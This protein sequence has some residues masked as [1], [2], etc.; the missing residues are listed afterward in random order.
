[1]AVIGCRLREE[2]STFSIDS[3]FRRMYQHQYLIETNNVNDLQI[4][5]YLGALTSTPDPLP[6]IGAKYHVT[7]DQD[8][9]AFLLG[10]Q[11]K[12][13]E[14]EKGSRRHWLADCNWGPPEP[15]Q[16]TTF[17]ENPL[18]RPAKYSLEWANYTRVLETDISG[19]PVL[20]SADDLFEAI[21][22][23]DA[24]PVLVVTKN[25]W[26]L[27]IIIANAIAYKNAVNSDTFHGAGP[28]QAKMESITSGQLLFENGY[29]FYN[30]T[31]R[32]QFNDTFWDM[33]LV[34]RGRQCYDRPKT[35]SIDDGMGGM[36]K[37][38]TKAWPRVKSG[39]HKGEFLELCNLNPD[40]TQRDDT[41][42]ALFKEPAYRIYPEKPFNALGI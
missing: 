26:P 33:K 6:K 18:N 25:E 12:R 36:I 29:D 32:I 35:D 5:V 39:E 42:P 10:A 14:E 8:N 20:N 38:A 2:G 9:N 28:R 4:D 23:D 3:S 37:L 31:Y 30:V 1:M 19:K 40:G 24:R 34:D 7:N 41:L 13:Y 15:G 16:G 27:E 21:E 11:L 17:A 22:Q